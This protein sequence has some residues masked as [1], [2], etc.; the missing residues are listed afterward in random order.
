MNPDSWKETAQWVS[1]KNPVVTNSVQGLNTMASKHK[2]FNEFLRPIAE[3]LFTDFSSCNHK[4]NR[5][6]R[7]KIFEIGT[8]SI[9]YTC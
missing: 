1:Y 5:L 7:F 6:Y 2:R 3:G 8:G 4:I 9:L